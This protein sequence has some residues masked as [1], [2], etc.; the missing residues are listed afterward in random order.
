MR[1]RLQRR[2]SAQELMLSN[3]GAGE[4]SWESLGVQKWSIQKEI[5]PEYSLEG[6]MLKLKL[7]YFGHLMWRDDSL[8]KTMMWGK[9]E[10]KR[11]R[12]WQRMRWFNGTTDSMDIEFEQ[13]PGD[14]EGQGSLVSCSSEVHSQTGL[15]DW[16]ARFTFQDDTGFTS[17]MHQK[18]Y[19]ESEFTFQ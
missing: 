4:D 10:G 17:Q 13:T 16:T 1:V 15:S 6:L 19:I 14:S 11:R 7:Q 12:G 5:N 18:V 3:C 8:E 9:I 2:L